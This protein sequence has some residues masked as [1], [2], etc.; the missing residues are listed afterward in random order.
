MYFS[1]SN[2][3]TLLLLF[4]STPLLVYASQ[5]TIYAW[6]CPALFWVGLCVIALIESR[7]SPHI[8]QD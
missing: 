8:P 7:S 5:H 2:L 3:L 1:K 4:I 6:L